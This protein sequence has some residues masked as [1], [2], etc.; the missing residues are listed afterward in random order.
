[1]SAS[2]VASRR[3][4]NELVLV[5]MAAVITGS[6]YLLASLGRTA[7]I[8]ANL[9]PFL[10]IVLG[11]LV[12]AHVA[13]RILAAGADPVLLPLAAL[14]CGLGYVMIVRV[15]IRE[16]FAGLQ[17]V[18]TFIG[19]GMYVLVLLLVRRVPDLRRYQWTLLFAGTALLVSPMVPGIGTSNGTNA[20]LW[21]DLGPVNFQP[22]EFAKIC[23]AIFFA[24]YLAERRELI[25]AGTWRVGPFNLPEPRHLLPILFAW[26]FSVLVLVGQK[27]LGSS[28]LFFALFVVLLWVATERATFLVMGGVLFAGAAVIAW[29]MFANVQD[30]V[31]LWLDP[32]SRYGG[33]TVATDKGRQAVQAWFAFA[34]G[35][36]AGTGLG[37]GAPN[38]IPAVQNDY[39]FAAIGEE[40]GLIGATAII[41]A[42]MLIVGSGLAVATRAE[43]PF[44]KLLATGLTT[45][46]GVQAFVI[47][48]G[49]TRLLPLT[50]VTLPFVSYGGSSLVAN[51]VL[52][53]LLMRISDSS[54]R[55]NRE[56][57]DVPTLG[58]RLAAR[59]LRR[60]LAKQQR[61]ATVIGAAP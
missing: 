53:G 4:N 23:L 39:I 61:A 56:I 9:V 24:A 55:R 5:L 48:A 41:M 43:R 44:E 49:V 33:S 59:R 47:I 46:L 27:D 35:G 32:W 11:L 2:P 12:A 31:D 13:T 6:G 42:F 36:L 7:D 29:W 25:A 21:V 57:P 60:R 14:L 18:W 51:F 16:R 17:T 1:V 45:I 50:G 22:G 58:E 15:D 8:P 19:V 52:L 20:R 3:R 40:L 10:L 28:L 37:Q 26:A 34:N 38:K 54:A 30:R